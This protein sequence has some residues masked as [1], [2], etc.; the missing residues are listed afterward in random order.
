M[1]PTPDSP[2]ATR[3]RQERSALTRSSLLEAA[4]DEFAAHGYDAASTRA[5]A[6][7]ANTQQPQINYHFSS[8]EALWRAAVDLLFERLDDSMRQTVAA[9]EP[10]T[11]P[12]ESFALGVRALVLAVASLPQLNRVMVHETT[13]PSDRLRWIV[14]RHVQ[15]RFT[16][17]TGDWE[18]LRA[19]GEVRN[20]DPAVVYYS[21]IG[22][23]SLAY[24]NAPE[25]LLLG[26]DTT[27]EAFVAAHADAMV[28]MFL[29]GA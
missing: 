20:I 21:L 13:A 9:A 27:S 7:A 28:A 26:H 5:I 11:T 8:K 16:V 2:P 1:T 17:L 25:A 4:L 19:A 12:R 24:V 22:A 29:D 14:E 18:E 6:A 3:R 23:A 15:A 10:P